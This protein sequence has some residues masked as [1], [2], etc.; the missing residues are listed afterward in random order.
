[1]NPFFVSFQNSDAFGKC[2]FFTLFILSII[3]WVLLVYKLMLVKKSKKVC[4]QF[5]KVFEENKH[6]LL[7]FSFEDLKAQNIPNPFAQIFHTLKE[8][9]IET[10]NKNRFFLQKTD[11][12]AKENFLSDVDLQLI[13]AQMSA[14]IS[15]E[16]HFFEKN[17]FVLATIVTLAPFLGLLGTVWGIL[18]TF[19][20]LSSSLMGNAN[21]LSGLSMALGTT[22]VGLLVAIPALIAYNFLKNIL[23]VFLK[24]M[25]GFSQKILTSLELQYRRVEPF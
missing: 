4:L 17:L 14:K 6:Q 24:E 21:L 2:I 3:S 19:S 12:T 16:L 22:V 8:T 7:S 5:E 13:E 10:L 20:N 25:E 9:S 23:K 11:E 1:M 15:K 18:V